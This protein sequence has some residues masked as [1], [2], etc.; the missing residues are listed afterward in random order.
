[1]TMLPLLKALSVAHQTCKRRCS[2]SEHKYSILFLLASYIVAVA[3]R[4]PI[5]QSWNY[6]IPGRKS[7]YF[8][9]NRG[10]AEAKALLFA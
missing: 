3:G 7:N 1:M 4:L 5:Q 2:Y 6:K 10:T 8:T 9:E